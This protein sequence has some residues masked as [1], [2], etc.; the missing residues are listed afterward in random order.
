[1]AKFS[2]K[3]LLERWSRGIIESGTFTDDLP[4]DVVDSKWL[5]YRGA[6]K[7]EISAAEKRLGK[8]LPPSYRDFLP[9]SNGW[10]RTTHFI[11]QLATDRRI[12]RAI[13]A[14]AKNDKSPIVRQAAK[15]ALADRRE[16]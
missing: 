1:M 5:G 13:R 7:G 4:A 3:H 9:T 6:T 16:H 8:K 12:V 2:W 14:L 11:A 15:W 10:R